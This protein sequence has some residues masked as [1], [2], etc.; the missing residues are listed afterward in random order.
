MFRPARFVCYNFGLN[1]IFLF[2]S[3]H[4]GFARTC[5]LCYVLFRSVYRT[6]VK[7]D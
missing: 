3:F 5:I 2:P 6:S 4:M 7:I 1:L